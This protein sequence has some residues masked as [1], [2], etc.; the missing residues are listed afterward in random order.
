M[1]VNGYE[2]KPRADLSRAY[3]SEANLSGA[4]LSKAN[5][6]KANLS[7]A[8]LYATKNIPPLLSAQLTI[9]AQGTLL[10][11]KMCRE[12]I[13]TLEIPTHAKRSNATTRKCRAEYAVVIDTPEHKPA[14]SKRNTN[15]I[16]EEGKTVR[17]H[18]WDDNRWKECSGGIHFFLTKEEAEAY[19]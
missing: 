8:N 18:K 2:I 14:K 4:D 5:L 19:K 13:V 16:Y 11:Y 6:S 17:A 9:V 1:I 15:C 7:G 3:L 10:V 12:G